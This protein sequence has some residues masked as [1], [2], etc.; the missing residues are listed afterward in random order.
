[1][2]TNK[3]REREV[4]TRAAKLDEHERCVRAFLRVCA[5]RE[6]ELVV[7]SARARAVFE[8]AYGEITGT[9]QI[10]CRHGRTHAETCIECWIP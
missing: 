9:D 3:Q 10:R 7:D 1:M 4:W 6:R 8:E 2:T 5:G